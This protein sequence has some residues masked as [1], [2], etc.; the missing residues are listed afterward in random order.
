[1]RRLLTLSAPAVIAVVLAGCTA[2]DLGYP[3]LLP[4]PIESRT[5]A[6]PVR[7]DPVAVPDPALDAR[8]AE[9]RALA[10]A[11]VQRFQPAAREAEARVAVARG[12][13]AGSD[14]WLRA[15]TA[16][17]DLAPIRGETT[18]IVS[19]LEEVAIARATAGEPPYPALDA[20]IAE[21]GAIAQQQ[22]DR[23]AALEDALGG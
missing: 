9:Q 6:E 4:R 19:A 23:V 14:A 13:A 11:A 7:A 3:S 2:P 17:A 18:Q 22:G 12:T 15:Q 1:M 5:D 10:K 16:L 21:L 8:I 20:A